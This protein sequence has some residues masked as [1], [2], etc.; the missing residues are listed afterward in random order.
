MITNEIA[1]AISAN[2]ILSLKLVSTIEIPD[3]TSLVMKNSVRPLEYLIVFSLIC[4][5]VSFIGSPEQ[6]EESLQ[7]ISRTLLLS[8]MSIVILDTLYERILCSMIKFCQVALTSPGIDQER[9]WDV[10]DNFFIESISH[11]HPVLQYFARDLFVSVLKN[12]SSVEAS[13]LVFEQITDILKE[14]DVTYVSELNEI[15]VYTAVDI[16]VTIDDP[17]VQDEMLNRLLLLSKR[18]LRRVLAIHLLNHSNGN[19]IIE[20]HVMKSLEGVL[21]NMKSE[22]SFSRRV[23]FLL[24]C[25]FLRADKNERISLT[26]CL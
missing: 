1:V 6:V 26:P 19:S 17:G 20:G 12:C 22:S 8:T 9:I 7:I 11:G 13:K 2:S 15:L 18:G 4:K 25:E 10:I 5:K 3:H 24:L 14:G 21:S 23:S 16:V